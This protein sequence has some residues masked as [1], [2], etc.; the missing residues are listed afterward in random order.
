MDG[1][2]VDGPPSHLGCVLRSEICGGMM[3]LSLKIKTVFVQCG[4]W[5]L[6]CCQE[7][8]GWIELMGKR[9]SV[10]LPLCGKNP[11]ILSCWITFGKMRQWGLSSLYGPVVRCMLFRS[12]PSSPEFL[13]VPIEF[14]T[15]C[16]SVHAADERTTLYSKPWYHWE[17]CRY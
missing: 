12:C 10:Q 11:L 4:H 16:R 5:Q 6:P 13:A 17:P 9:W 8:H 7:K 15:S 3:F 1:K 2:V 14:V